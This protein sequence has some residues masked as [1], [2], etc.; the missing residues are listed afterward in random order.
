MIAD[1]VDVARPWAL[2]LV[3]V[4]A[5]LGGAVWLAARRAAARLAAHV[6]PH[7]LVPLIGRA[8]RKHVHSALLIGAAAT[9]LVVGL[10]GLR[11]GYAFEEV[12]ST[13]IDLVIALDVSD[14]MKVVDGTDGVTRLDR[15]RREIQDLLTRIDGDRVALVGFAGTAWL[16]CPLTLDTA[17]ASM[18]LDELD[19]DLASRQGTALGVALDVSREAFESG[20]RDARAILL[21]TDGE[22]HGGDALEAARKAADEGIR[23]FAIGIGRDEGSPIPDGDGGFRRDRKGELILSKLDEPTLQSVAE[24]TGGGYVRSTLG[25][26]DLQQ[27]YDLGIKQQTTAEERAGGLRKIWNDR[28]AWLVALAIVLLL[29]ERTNAV[30]KP[31][32]VPGET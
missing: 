20:A 29:V 8:S 15:A 2:W 30:R 16:A 21:L 22:D 6:D 18:F 14:S 28:Y 17:A 23:V 4:A 19:P 5:A 24:A 9:S 32:A 13:G 1:W 3:P 12:H 27:V 10:A 7:L 25:D 26:V 31:A 11:V